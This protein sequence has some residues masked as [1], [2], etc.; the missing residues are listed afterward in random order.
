[1]LQKAAGKE[2]LPKMK[3]QQSRNISPFFFSYFSEDT[4]QKMQKILRDGTYVPQE[5]LNITDF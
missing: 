2:A 1:M 5:I 4:I 3:E